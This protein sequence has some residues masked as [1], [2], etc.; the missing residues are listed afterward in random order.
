MNRGKERVTYLDVDDGTDNL[1]DHTAKLGRGGRVCPHY[2]TEYVT[3]YQHISVSLIRTIIH[4]PRPKWHPEIRRK[5]QF[6]NVGS[7]DT[8][9]SPIP[10]KLTTST[11]YYKAHY[12]SPVALELSL[13][14]PRIMFMK[15]K[16]RKEVQQQ[17]RDRPSVLCEPRDATHTDAQNDTAHKTVKR[18]FGALA[19]GLWLLGF[20]CS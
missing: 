14:N 11:Q 7:F 1:G 10:Q 3:R 4:T 15:E 13:A 16:W 12:P 18:R 8:P 19:A 17:Q 5:P 6:Q 2:T 9:I 20:G